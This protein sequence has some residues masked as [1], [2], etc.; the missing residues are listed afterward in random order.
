[1]KAFIEFGAHTGPNLCDWL[2]DSWHGIFVEPHPANL[3]EL[4]KYL[5]SYEGCSYQVYSGIVLGK[6]TIGKFYDMRG[7]IHDKGGGAFAEPT[8]VSRHDEV[9]FLGEG[10]GSLEVGSEGPDWK[11]KGCLSILALTL[12]MLVQN[13]PYPIERLEI[14]C[15][16]AEVDIFQNYS[17]NVRPKEIKVACHGVDTKR[18]LTDI[19]ENVGYSVEDMD[20]EHLF[21]TI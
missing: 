8:E 12:D 21:C 9:G 19:F 15:E 1:M 11:V 3:I 4:F 2:L 10:F 6:T 5:E 20:E 16:F 18:T 13:S 17:F 7:N 14:D